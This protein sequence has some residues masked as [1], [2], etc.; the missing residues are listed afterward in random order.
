MPSGS[1]LPACR[2]NGR[3]GTLPLKSRQGQALQPGAS[4]KEKDMSGH[5]LITG[6]IMLVIHAVVWREDNM[7]E[8]KKAS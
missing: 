7:E 2:N 1:H 3:F 5:L 6:A 4:E 8:S